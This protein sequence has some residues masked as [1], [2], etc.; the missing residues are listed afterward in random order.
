M[1]KHIAIGQAANEFER[2]AIAFLKSKL[3]DSFAILSNFEYKQ[4]KKIYEVDLAIIA[5]QC[6]F[7][8]DIKHILGHIDIYEKWCSENREPFASPLAK[9]RDHAKVMSSLIANHNKAQSQVL[10]KIYVQAAILMTARDST[11]VDHNGRDIESI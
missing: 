2:N 10:R 6:L 11:V 9:L 8:V 1:A 3:P 7:L 4:N 5:P